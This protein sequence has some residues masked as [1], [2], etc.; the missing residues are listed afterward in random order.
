VPEAWQPSPEHRQIARDLRIPFDL[1]LAKFRDHEFT[2]PKRDPDATFRN[3][4]RNAKPSAAL[5][6]PPPN[7]HK[8]ATMAE[9]DRLMG[10][11]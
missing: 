5:P 4:I 9:I 3:W 7:G 1:E 11:A 10:Q 6:P 8:F 2:V